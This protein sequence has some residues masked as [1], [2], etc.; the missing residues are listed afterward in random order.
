M[1]ETI[2]YYNANGSNVYAL[3]LDANKV[4]DRVIYV[5]LVLL[6]RKASPLI[7]RLLLNMYTGVRLYHPSL[8]HV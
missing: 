2:C 4:F 6:K 1:Q 3:M 5:K 8:P 7:L